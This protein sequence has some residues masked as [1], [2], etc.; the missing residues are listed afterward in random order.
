VTVTGTLVEQVT[1]EPLPSVTLRLSGYCVDCPDRKPLT[2]TTGPDGVF[3][4][5][6]V[7]IGSDGRSEF[8]LSPP[9]S[10]GADPADRDA[11]SYLWILDPKETY[12][13]T[14]GEFRISQHPPTTDRKEKGVFVPITGPVV[15]VGKVLFFDEQVAAR[16]YGPACDSGRQKGGPPAA[17]A[18]LTRASEKGSA[19]KYDD[20]LHRALAG[21]WKTPFPA[22][23]C[24]T[25]VEEVIGEYSG[26]SWENKKA[27]AV[28]WRLRLIDARNG[29]ITRQEFSAAPPMVTT[30]YKT[31]GDPTPDLIAWLNDK[32]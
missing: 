11:W 2:A 26:A 12:R 32:H 18:T 25:V 28:T 16:A 20:H 17:F 15:D 13:G 14:T 21:S 10:P 5:E 8:S 7:P 24:V 22:I 6:G 30:Q 4:F 9:K 29:T 31:H 1:G 27:T 3:R 19:W 23:F